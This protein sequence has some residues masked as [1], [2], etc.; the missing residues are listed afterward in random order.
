MNLPCLWVEMVSGAA[1]GNIACARFD[2]CKMG[3]VADSFAG[4]VGGFLGGQIFLQLFASDFSA[5]DIDFFLSSVGGGA[6]GGA[7]LAGVVGSVRGALRRRR[8]S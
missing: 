2:N 7:L 5:S 1:G 3:A 6:V 8:R 4:V